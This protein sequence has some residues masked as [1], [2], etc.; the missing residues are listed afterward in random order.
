[1]FQRKSKG[2]A[3]FYT[4]D[5]GGRHEMTP[6]EY[7]RWAQKKSVEQNI[8]FTGTA[9]GIEAMIR[10]GHSQDGDLFL[11]FNVCGNVLSRVG[12]DALIKTALEDPDVS[13]VLI[14]RRDRL[15]R[16]D[17]PVDGV[18]LEDL[19]RKEGLT[20][21]F[22]D[23]VCSPLPKGSRRD[24][25]ELIGTLIDYDASGK[26]R[27]ELAQKM[28]YT[29]IS[30]AKAGF[31]VGGRPP[32]GFDR[33]L[34]REDG[35]RVRK[36]DEG[37]Y[38][39]KSGHHVLWL[40]APEDDPR[41]QNI[42]RILEMLESTPASRVA[43][44]LTSEGIPSPDAGRRRKEKKTGI[45]H[46]VSGVWRQ[47]SIVN[48]ARNPLLRAIVSY[49][50]R[51]MGDQL[52]FSPDGPRELEES[53]RRADGKA[54]VIQNPESVRITAPAKFEPLVDSDRHDKLLAILD[55]RAGSQ[56]GKPRSREPALNPLGSRI[57]DL[58]CGWPM[59]RT[60]KYKGR[61]RKKDGFGYT[62]DLYRQSHG[63]ACRHNQI[64]GP[65]VTRFLL[66]CI[67]QRI[68]QPS[69]LAKLKNRLQKLAEQEMVSKKP[70]DEVRR[71]EVALAEVQ[72]QID[73]VARNMAL[74]ENLQ[75]YK[76]MARVFEELEQ[77][78]NTLEIELS[79]QSEPSQSYSPQLYQ[80]PAFG[81]VHYL[82]RGSPRSQEML[83]TTCGRI[84][85]CVMP[86]A[87]PSSS[88]KSLLQL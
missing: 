85:G 20:L 57:F 30:L 1:M 72:Q 44:A 33:W 50:R 67:R 42:L 27:R 59:Y 21:V 40:P 6:G 24:I 63:A 84:A 34:V 60:P 47:T 79:W 26:F 64:D 18:K 3:L 22:M 11:D 71:T 38:V 54:K 75:Q 48:I 32:Y 65:L 45:D 2:R 31:S 16:P 37:E 56:K 14:P 61:K 46:S 7:V 74:A 43:A 88:P 77:R 13:H 15:A 76:V 49:G 5:S 73:Q 9:E 17:D 62:C 23:K 28:I 53:D 29:Q 52:R 66:G 41:M 86:V 68:L 39:R 35:T 4:R 81:I 83:Q 25:A 8:D 80:F 69:I 55:E 78:R 51:S 58:D 70:D 82:E 87:P 36:L 12:L 19:L 10:G